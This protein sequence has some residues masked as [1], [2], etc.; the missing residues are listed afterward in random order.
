MRYD[1]YW[2]VEQQEKIQQLSAMDIK[3]DNHHVRGTS[4]LL[5]QMYLRMF[6]PCATCGRTQDELV[7]HGT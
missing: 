3:L 6:A 2:A 5:K 4:L 1:N 7:I